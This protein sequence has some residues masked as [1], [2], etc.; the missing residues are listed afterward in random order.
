MWREAERTAVSP[1]PERKSVQA[2]C[3]NSPQGSGALG[4]ASTSTASPRDPTQRE[5]ETI[6]GGDDSDTRAFPVNAVWGIKCQS[7]FLGRKG[8]AKRVSSSRLWS[9]LVPTAGVSGSLPEPRF[10]SKNA[11]VPPGILTGP[12]PQGCPVTQ[13]VLK[14]PSNKARSTAPGGGSGGGAGAGLA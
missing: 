5:T 6:D 8:P 9:L 11:C 13:R 1:V 14:Q 10:W 12:P 2:G 4:N 7:S 3:P